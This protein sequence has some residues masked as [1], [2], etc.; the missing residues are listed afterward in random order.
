MSHNHLTYQT[1]GIDAFPL[2]DFEQIDEN[3]ADTIRKSL[4]ESQFVI[5]W[6]DEPTFIAD[7]SVVP[8]TT[9]NYLQCLTL[10]QTPEWSADEDE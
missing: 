6:H 3:S 8:V 5:K 4:D 10:M 9:L 1:I 2:I 7:G